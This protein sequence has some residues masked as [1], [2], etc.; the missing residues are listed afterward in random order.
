MVGGDHDHRVVEQIAGAEGVEQPSQQPVDVLHLQ[1]VTL[2]PL[3]DLPLRPRPVPAREPRVLLA[4]DRILAAVGQVAP[5][6]V[7][8]RRVD[9]QQRRSRALTLERGDR[10]LEPG[11]RVVAGE[12]REHVALQVRPSLELARVGHRAG[13]EPLPD[14]IDGGKPLAQVGRQHQMLDDDLQV[15]LERPQPV[16]RP[17]PDVAAEPLG[18]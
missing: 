15:G 8:E 17:R 7:R 4:V 3:V 10:A 5:R 16:H 18:A 2:E 12:P 6:P 13:V 11:R 9:E 14:A 1:D